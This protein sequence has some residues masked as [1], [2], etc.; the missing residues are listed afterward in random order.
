[1]GKKKSKVRSKIKAAGVKATRA[2][3]KSAVEEKALEASIIQAC[4]SGDVTKL[5]RWAQQHMHFVLRGE[6]ILCY[7]AGHG[8]LDV[9]QCPV[10]E[11]GTDVN[12]SGERGCSPLYIAA[13]F[14]HVAIV[15]DLAKQGADLGRVASNGAAPL[16]IAASWGR[17]D[18]DRALTRCR[19]RCQR[20]PAR[21]GRVH[22]VVHCSLK[23]PPACGALPIKIESGRQ[24][25]M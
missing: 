8:T 18:V 10:T 21:H 19:A 4:I 12:Q 11:L 7:A 25:R 24:P 2:R 13:Q 9:V 3:E 5:R 17:L 23:W 14:G 6:P 22:G 16:Y 15:Q 1:M 20:R